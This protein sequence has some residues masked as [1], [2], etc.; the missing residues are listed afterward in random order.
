M[1]INP[2]PETSPSSAHDRVYRGLRTRIM[3]GEIGPG[4]AL[5]LRGIGKEFEV[6]MTPAR[7]AVRRL[8][9]EGALTLSTSGRVATPE[10]SNE[11]IEELAALRSLIEVELASRAM[12]RA[13]M[14][15]IERLQTIN[16]AISEAVA[17]KDAVAYIR[18]NL[19]FHR[20]LYLRAQAPAMLAMAETV[21]LQLGPTM[22]ALYGRLRRTEPP[23]FHRLIIAALRAGDEPG[24]RLAVRSDVTQGLKMLAS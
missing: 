5:T 24:L 3:H 19:E 7:E 11:R 17:H 20:T 14:A 16:G 21:W 9:A 1:L 15:L 10:L 12:P 18:T 8:V 4:Q 22:R 13:H 2:R 23:H 6:S